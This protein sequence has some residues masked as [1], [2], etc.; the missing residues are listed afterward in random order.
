M[1][2][3]IHLPLEERHKVLSDMVADPPPRGTKLGKGSM[4]GRVFPLV[5]GRQFLN[6][7]TVTRTSTKKED[8]Q[9]AFEDALKGEVLFTPSP[10]PIFCASNSEQLLETILQ[11]QRYAR[12]H[13]I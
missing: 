10:L 8:I 3:V 11:Q 2:S 9:E 12:E 6:G 4:V 7:M 13:R 1:Q 5:P